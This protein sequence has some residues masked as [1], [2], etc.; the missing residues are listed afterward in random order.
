MWLLL[1]ACNAPDLSG[2]VTATYRVELQGERSGRVWLHQDPTAERAIWS[3]DLAWDLSI[4]EDTGSVT[5]R[6]RQGD[7]FSSHNGALD[8]LP[9]PVRPL[10][11]WSALPAEPQGD[12][13]VAADAQGVALSDA[14]GLAMV[15]APGVLVLREDLSE[16][17][18]IPGIRRTP[19]YS[20]PGQV[21]TI[22]LPVGSPKQHLAVTV[23]VDQVSEAQ[24]DLLAFGGV[25]VARAPSAS[26][27][28]L[29]ALKLPC[30]IGVFKAGIPTLAE[31]QARPIPPDC[32]LAL[33][34]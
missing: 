33:E 11:A 14:Q 17:P 34:P 2:P 23:D 19:I 12:W 10:L 8:T 4:D 15:V 7:A 30:E 31:L 24:A 28:P 9:L 21:G 6:L 25:V 3:P 16:P 27:V 32:A 20:V 5:A 13:R 29:Q 26:P 1:L 22:H 18:R